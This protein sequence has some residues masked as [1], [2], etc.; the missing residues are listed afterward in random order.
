MLDGT[1]YWFKNQQS[2]VTSVAK[3]VEK[4]RGSIHC[5]T[6]CS[7]RELTGAQRG[8]FVVADERGGEQVFEA[9]TSDDAMP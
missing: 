5:T 9:P 4:P 7:A 3:C 1:L 8:S 6:G 2:N